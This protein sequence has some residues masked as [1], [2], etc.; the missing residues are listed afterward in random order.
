MD[1][2]ARDRFRRRVLA[3][4]DLASAGLGLLVA[5]PILGRGDQLRPWALAAIPLLVVINKAAGLYDCDEHRVRI[6]RLGACLRARGCTA[7]PKAKP[8][9]GGRRVEDDQR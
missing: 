9:A 1:V 4:A 8:S 3:L 7:R 5:V 2:A 6:S